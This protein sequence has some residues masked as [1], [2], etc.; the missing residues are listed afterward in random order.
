[1]RVL[2]PNDCRMYEDG[3]QRSRLVI[4]ILS[5]GL[6]V[7]G[8][9]CSNLTSPDGE[10]PDSLGPVRAKPSKPANPSLMNKPVRLNQGGAKAAKGDTVMIRRILIAY[11]GA[12]GAKNDIKRTKAEAQ[13][14]ATDI[15]SKLKEPNADFATLAKKHS[16]APDAARGGLLPA[17]QRSA[18]IDPAL[19]SAAF[20]TKVHEVSGILDTKNGYLILQRLK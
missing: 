3:M 1:M 4:T 13:K 20:R 8:A 14:L 16:D 17:F 10:N 19:K 11:E 2:R 7:I 6:V 18:D 5:A 15:A 9:A 12:E